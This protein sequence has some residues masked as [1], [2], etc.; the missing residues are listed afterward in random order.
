MDII[1]R[2]NK[3]KEKNSISELYEIY[4][5]FFKPP[6][7]VIPIKIGKGERIVR[8]RIN[9]RKWRHFKNTKDLFCPPPN[10]TGMLRAN[11]AQSPMFYAAKFIANS[12]APIPRAIVLYETSKF[13]RD[14]NNKGIQRL[15]YSVWE[16]TE[17]MTLILVPFSKNYDKL[18]IRLKELEKEWRKR[19]NDVDFE[20]DKLKICEFLST[21]FSK[22]SSDYFFTSHYSHFACNILS[23]EHDGIAYPTVKFEGDGLN[24]AIKPESASNKLRL[25]SANECYL[26]KRENENT[27][28]LVNVF[29]AKILKNG[30]TRY[31]KRDDFKSR[32]RNWKPIMSGLRFIN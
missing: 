25:I 16:V 14:T 23:R 27:G 21:E 20:K 30:K 11:I 13:A 5:Y 28:Y 1:E 3:I 2:L 17:E 4:D 8:V 19:I 10:K 29:D 12:D 15:T 18:N 6:I 7:S 31:I 9:D 22:D 26:I 32:S 24:V